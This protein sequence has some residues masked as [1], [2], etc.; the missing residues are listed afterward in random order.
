MDTDAIQT[1]LHAGRKYV[2]ISI[3]KWGAEPVVSYELLPEG[4]DAPISEHSRFGG[5]VVG[6][7]W[8]VGSDKPVV[9]VEPGAG[10]A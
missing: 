10:A 3:S 5:Y 6:V 1:R 2:Q 4:E 9:T 8:A 7:Q